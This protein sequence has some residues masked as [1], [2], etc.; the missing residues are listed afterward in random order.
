MKNESF[1]YEYI[2]HMYIVCAGT[3]Q[4]FKHICLV[5]DVVQLDSIARLY[6][7]LKPDDVL[8]IWTFSCKYRW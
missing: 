6:Q 7:C 4:I 1:S 3:V 2:V 5:N 8:I